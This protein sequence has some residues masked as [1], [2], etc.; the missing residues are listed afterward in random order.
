MHRGKLTGDS[1]AA[2]VYRVL[3]ARSGELISGPELARA[4]ANDPDWPLTAV[5]TRVDEVRSHPDLPTGQ[6]VPSAIQIGKGFY[7][8][9]EVEARAGQLELASCLTG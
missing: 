4:A 5:S 6:I 7:Y 9:L 8:T 1:A 2:R 3:K